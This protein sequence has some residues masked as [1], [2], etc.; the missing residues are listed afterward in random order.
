[1]KE[2]NTVESSHHLTLKWVETVEKND[3]TA[4]YEY[5]AL[6]SVPGHWRPSSPRRGKSM[7]S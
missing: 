4:K 1:M 7:A 3:T 2:Q 5:D 6:E